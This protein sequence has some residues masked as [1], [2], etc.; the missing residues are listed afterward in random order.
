MVW[1]GLQRL[2]HLVSNLVASFHRLPD[3]QGMP[4]PAE[5]HNMIRPSGRCC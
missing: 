3:K 4:L 5:R 1:H 2:L